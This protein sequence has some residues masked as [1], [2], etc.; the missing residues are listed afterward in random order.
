MEKISADLA[1][2]NMNEVGAKA[3]ITEGHPHRPVAQRGH[4]V[5]SGLAAHDT[6]PALSVISTDHNADR[7]QLISGTGARVTVSTHTADMPGLAVRAGLLN[8][9]TSDRAVLSS[10]QGAALECNLIGTLP[11]N[12]PGTITNFADITVPV[13]TCGLPM[14]VRS[15]VVTMKVGHVHISEMV[16]TNSLAA[17][18]NRVN[19]E[20]CTCHPA[21]HLVEINAPEWRC[22]HHM[23]VD[24]TVNFV[25]PNLAMNSETPIT[26][27]TS[28][29]VTGGL[30]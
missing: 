3:W 5:P 19:S 1:P 4:I 7:S 21:L 22:V 23:K 10:V 30:Q 6:G 28:E 24:P 8:D 9:H 20:E 26:P 2:I 29:S 12:L 15:S 13:P 18:V 11:L 17:P 25:V 27:A 16:A 14:T